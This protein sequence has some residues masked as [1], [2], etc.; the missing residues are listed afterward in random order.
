MDHAETMRGLY[1]ALNA[2]DLDGW[3]CLSLNRRQD[4]CCPTRK[5][6]A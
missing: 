6:A 1:A 5:D 4:S 3:W 2:G